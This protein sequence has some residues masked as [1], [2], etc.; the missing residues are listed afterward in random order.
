MES[1]DECI[2]V[3]LWEFDSSVW[4]KCRPERLTSYIVIYGMQ[5]KQDAYAILRTLQRKLKCNGQMEY[6]SFTLQETH[7]SYF[8]LSLN[9]HH[10][11]KITAFLLA[12]NICTLEQITHRKQ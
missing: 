5:D 8:K 1:K 12:K 11:D 6:H 2:K 9:G 3:T 4:T 10:M 7:H